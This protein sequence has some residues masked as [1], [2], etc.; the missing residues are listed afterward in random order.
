MKRGIKR[1]MECAWRGSKGEVNKSMT[2]VKMYLNQKEKDGDLNIFVKEV[3][4]VNKIQNQVPCRPSHPHMTARHTET[5]KQE[6][7]QE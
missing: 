3:N 6:L 5:N 4:K 1:E 7:R 2:A